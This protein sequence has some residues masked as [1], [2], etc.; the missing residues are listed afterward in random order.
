MS[1]AQQ[2]PS[3]KKNKLLNV[4]DKNLTRAQKLIDAG[5]KLADK[6]EKY[7]V[8]LKALNKL[9]TVIMA[10]SLTIF[11]I[12]TSVCSLSIYHTYQSASENTQSVEK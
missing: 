1:D 4:A 5:N 2:V 7:L 12:V 8:K 3:D 9:V 10:I 6:G 11:L